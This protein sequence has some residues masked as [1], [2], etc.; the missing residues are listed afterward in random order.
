MLAGQPTHHLGARLAK[1]GNNGNTR[2]AANDRDTEAEGLGG[3]ASRLGDKGRGTDDVKGG[4]TEEPVGVD[5]RMKW[6]S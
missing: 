3:L 6:V 2:V 1:E 4:N 5:Q